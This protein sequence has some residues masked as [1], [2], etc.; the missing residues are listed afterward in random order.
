MKSIATF[1]LPNKYV[2]PR[3]E[4]IYYWSSKG[5]LTELIKGNHY[6]LIIASRVVPE[7]ATL[8]YFISEISCPVIVIAEGGEV[9]EDAFA[10][11]GWHVPAQKVID[12]GFRVVCVSKE[13]ERI[14]REW[15]LFPDPI[16]IPNGYDSSLFSWDNERSVKQRVDSRTKVISVGRMSPIKGYDLLIRAMARLPDT[17]SLTLVG[18]GDENIK[19]QLDALVRKLSLSKRITFLSDVSNE[20]VP[21][22]L[23]QHDLFCM[24]SRLESFGI[25]ALE[26]MGCGLPVVAS[27]VGGLKNLVIGGFNGL[28]FETENVDQLAEKL[29]MAARASWQH[30][31]ISVW[32]KKN[33][34][35][36]LWAERILQL[37]NERL[38]ANAKIA[39]RTSARARGLEFPAD[40]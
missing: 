15:R 18:G 24:P 23:R 36:S 29:S 37:A 19:R 7:G 8:S 6:D 26:A 20:E 39:K 14:V 27:N 10:F 5:L 35:W 13:M 32:A 40:E 4:L 2:W 25:A 17:F 11:K 34:D 30:E 12:A 9:L 16:T 22:L 31:A 28:S 1:H 21:P 33:Y 38:S 3:W